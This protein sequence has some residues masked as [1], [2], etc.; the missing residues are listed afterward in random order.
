MMKTWLTAGAVALSVG[1][2][3]TAAFAQTTT[4]PGEQVGLA[5][6][7]PLPEGVYAINTFTYRSPDGPNAT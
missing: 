4:V 1:M 6:G 5:V 7:A 2:S 3:A